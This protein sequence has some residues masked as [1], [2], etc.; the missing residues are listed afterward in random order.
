MKNWKFIIGIFLLTV[1]SA[2]LLNKNIESF[3]DPKGDLYLLLEA[4]GF[5]VPELNQTQQLMDP[6]LAQS[7]FN[8]VV[9]VANSAKYKDSN[10]NDIMNNQ[11]NNTLV[12]NLGLPVKKWAFVCCNSSVTPANYLI[13]MLTTQF[14]DL[15][16][17]LIDSEDDPSSIAAFVKLFNNMG[18]Q[19]KYAIVGGLR[20]SIPPLSKYGIVFDKFF[21]ECYTEGSLGQYNFYKG[22]P[23]KVNGA[24]C[25]DLNQ[26]GVDKFWSSIKSKLGQNDSIVPTVCGSGNCQEE[27]FGADC[28]DERLSNKNIDTLIKGNNSGRRDFAIWYGTG[29]QF[30]CMPS[31]DCLRISDAKTCTNSVNCT[32]SP[33][34]KNPNTGQKG[35][36]FGNT[37][38]KA[39]GC[40]TTW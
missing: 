1:L 4:P 8:N 14:P 39:W 29:Q 17:F 25:V 5:D 6:N 2:C 28:F 3:T 31:R 10:D 33:Y 40:A 26:A 18:A 9:V 37:N 13:N 34:K 16:G 22:L 19:Y 27:L 12:A 35:V 11:W 30:P 15:E 20:N 7:K 38:N 23:T 21:A 24:T 36:C 32:W